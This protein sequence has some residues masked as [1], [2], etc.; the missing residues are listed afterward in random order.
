ME[1]GDEKSEEEEHPNGGG[2]GGEDGTEEDS[3]YNCQNVE[4]NAK[5]NDKKQAK[6]SGINIGT[7]NI[8]N[9]RGN[10]L[11]LACEC[12]RRHNIDVA[13]LTET[14]LNGKHT[15]RAYGYNIVASK[16]PNVHQGG[17]AVVY[18]DSKNWHIESPTFY[19][20]NVLRCVLV[21]ERQRTT[22]V[23]V[24]IPPSETSLETIKNVDTALHNVN[25]DNTIILGDL[26]VNYANP[27]NAT[28]DINIV[29]ALDTYQM[30]SVAKQFRPRR[31]KNFNWTW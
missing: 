14:K 20:S 31:M 16:C 10:R 18:K 4:Q 17:V 21:H 25:I 1:G 12:L 6:F 29:D 9:G 3:Q 27:S 30:K 24:Y 7:W 5:Q 22:I 28:R 2:E 15:E 8:M 13:V 23:C 26:N 19:D 11:E